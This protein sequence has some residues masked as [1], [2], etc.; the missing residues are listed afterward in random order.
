MLKVKNITK[1][2][3]YEAKEGIGNTGESMCNKSQAEDVDIYK[4]IEKYGVEPLMR[5]SMAKEQLYL[6]NTLRFN[7]LQDAINAKNQMEEYYN[8]L[9]ARVRKVFHS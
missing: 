8:Q 7:N 5:Q 1:Y 4:C 6:D 9:P 3:T 2:D